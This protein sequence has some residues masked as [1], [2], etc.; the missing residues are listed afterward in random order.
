MPISRPARFRG[1]LLGLAVGDALGTTLEFSNRGTFRLI[2]DMTGG[3][4][5]RLA[6]GQ[7]TDDT[8]MA[9][10]LAAS[11]VECRG[12]DARDQ[13]ERYCRWQDEGYYSSTGRCFDIG[14]T[15]RAA[16]DR[17]RST[18]DPFAGPTLP[19]TAGNGCIT[20]LAPVPM[21]F[22]A[23]PD[24]ARA[25]SAE[26]SRITH[27]APEC[28]DACRLFGGMLQRA[29]VGETKEEVLLGE[30][31]TFQGSPALM[32]V[33]RGDYRQ[34]DEKSLRPS[35]YVVDCLE[36]ALWCFRK[37][38]S[39]ERAVLRAANLGGDADTTAAVCGQ[40]AGAFYGAQAIPSQWVSK[41]AMHEEIARLA[42]SLAVE[43]S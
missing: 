3:G 17:Y 11:L 29:L 40:L 26:S 41:L 25:N 21:F 10:C 15:V 34:K 1:A 28:L 16:L 36:A 24:S 5:F 4:P 22:C 19:N 37:T 32:M 13:I 8:S 2:T 20:R 42:D 12:F 38:R 30:A 31:Q 23:D 27:G 39:F 18:K 35:G 14:M 9:L 33:A 7:W 43:R 6:P